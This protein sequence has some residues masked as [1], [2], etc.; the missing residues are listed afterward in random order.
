MVVASLKSQKLATQKLG[1]D[2]KIIILPFI[3][4]I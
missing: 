4:K 2:D 1:N 3:K